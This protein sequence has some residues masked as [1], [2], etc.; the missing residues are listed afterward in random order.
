MHTWLF[1]SSDSGSLQSLYFIHTIQ[2]YTFTISWNVYTAYLQSDAAGFD[3]IERCV[4]PIE[5]EWSYLTS[6][7]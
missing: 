4:R 2:D 5:F 3:D 1:C 7:W 6:K